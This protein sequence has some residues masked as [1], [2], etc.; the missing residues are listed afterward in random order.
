MHGGSL[1]QA[2]KKRTS[3]ST[4][5]QG[6]V[7]K[8]RN[9][10]QKSL[11]PVVICPYLCSSERTRYV[12]RAWSLTIGT[13]FKKNTSH[14]PEVHLLAPR[15]SPIKIIVIV[16]VVIALILIQFTN[17]LIIIMIIIIP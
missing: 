16:T 13:P 14:E 6:A 10:L 12:L 2:S 5:R 11:C 15:A 4:G 3:K 1:V 7:L 9:S 17:I 8:H